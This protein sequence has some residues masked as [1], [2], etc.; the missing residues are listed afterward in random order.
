M[1]NREYRSDAQKGY[2]K[3]KFNTDYTSEV[4]GRRSNLKT[5]DQNE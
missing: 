4:I 5:S 2:D 3:S 1:S